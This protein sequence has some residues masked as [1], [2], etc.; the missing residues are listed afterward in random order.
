MIKPFT[1]SLTEYIKSIRTKTLIIACNDWK[2]ESYLRSNS[3]LTLLSV[4][5]LNLESAGE[6]TMQEI[7][8][9]I[10]TFQYK[11]I[12]LLADHPC[13][14]QEQ[15]I[16]DFVENKETYGFAKV[17]AQT[18][19]VLENDR[20]KYSDSL[21]TAM[22]YLRYQFNYLENYLKDY[23]FQELRAIPPIKG[24]VFKNNYKVYELE[25]FELNN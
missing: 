16:Q 18:K 22:V 23:F 19:I 14:I 11:Q 12:I 4:F 3:N 9:A 13:Q 25:G 24:I 10:K 15:V 6:Y 21:F 1:D 2:A 20:L 17:L 8:T 7:A 5:G